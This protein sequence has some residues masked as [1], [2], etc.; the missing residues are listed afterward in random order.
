[1]ADFYGHY[2]SEACA[3]NKVIG[4]D[5]ARQEAILVGLVGGA[6]GARAKAVRGMREIIWKRVGGAKGPVI[7]FAMMRE[8]RDNKWVLCG[9]TKDGVTA[10]VLMAAAQEEMKVEMFEVG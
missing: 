7:T 3:S 5:G 6:K 9:G 2:S 4:D 8:W 1:M 10:A